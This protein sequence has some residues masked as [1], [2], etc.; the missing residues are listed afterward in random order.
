MILSCSV[1]DRQ[2][3]SFCPVH[4]RRQKLAA[5]V[6]FREDNFCRK[7]STEPYIADNSPYIADDKPYFTDD[8]P[9][10]ADDKPYIADIAS[11]YHFVFDSEFRLFRP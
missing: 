11:S 2:F 1:L 4:R 10:I 3:L 6:S 7:L 9:Y 8:K 5:I